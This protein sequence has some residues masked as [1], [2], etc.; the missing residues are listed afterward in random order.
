MA[1]DRLKVLAAMMDQGVIPVFYHPDVE[2]CSKV[3]QA[4]ANGGP[5]ASSSPTAATSRPTPS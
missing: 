1:R 3:I 4:C 5:S 2:V